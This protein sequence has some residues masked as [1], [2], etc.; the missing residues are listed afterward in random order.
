MVKGGLAG[1]AERAALLWFDSQLPLKDRRRAASITAPLRPLLRM[2]EA[3]VALVSA[4]RW[5]RA[6]GS[7]LSVCAVRS[8]QSGQGFSCCMHQHS[9]ARQYHHFVSVSVLP[10]DEGLAP[11]DRGELRRPSEERTNLSPSCLSLHGGQA[12]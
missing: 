10:S 11:H 6:S 2:R 4:C 1:P 9:R 5:Q 8:A 3:F 7:L 12:C